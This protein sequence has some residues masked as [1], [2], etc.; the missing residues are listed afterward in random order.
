MEEKMKDF[1]SMSDEE[2]F[3]ELEK[4]IKEIEK[5][6]FVYPDLSVGRVELSEISA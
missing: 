2:I 1:S 3:A 6:S 5:E 4:K